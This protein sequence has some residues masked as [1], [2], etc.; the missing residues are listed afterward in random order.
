M[1]VLGLNLQ[2]HEIGF[3]QMVARG[4]VVFILALG[5]VRISAKRFLGRKTAFDF[6]LAIMLGSILSRAINGSAPF[7]PT[8]VTGFALILIHRVLAALAFRYHWVGEL[9]KGGEDVLIENGEVQ[10]D[11]LRRHFLTKRDLMEDL[12]LKSCENPSEVKIARVER[13]GDVSVIRLDRKE[14]PPPMSH[15]LT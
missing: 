10:E 3:G 14:T 15:T 7:F 13:S 11:A 1:D 5:M 8:L 2:A 6:I 12:R 9:V 4:V